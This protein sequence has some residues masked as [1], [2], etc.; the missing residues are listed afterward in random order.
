SRVGELIFCSGSVDFCG[1]ELRL[2]TDQ[3]LYEINNILIKHKIKQA[4]K[5]CFCNTTKTYHATVLGILRNVQSVSRSRNLITRKHKQSRVQFVASERLFSSSRAKTAEP[6]NQIKLAANFCCVVHAKLNQAAISQNQNCNND[7]Q[8]LTILYNN[9]TKHFVKISAIPELSPWSSKTS[10]WSSKIVCGIQH[11]QRA[12]HRHLNLFQST[13]Y[14]VVTFS[15]V[16]YGDF[17]P[18]IWPSQLYMV[19]MICVALIVLPTQNFIIML[20]A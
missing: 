8:C 13:Y 9:L 14:V 15:T 1:N 12:G 10:S 18:D 16:G 5:K 20:F 3:F 19:I 11:F 4:E 7:F 6:I 2:L 17:V